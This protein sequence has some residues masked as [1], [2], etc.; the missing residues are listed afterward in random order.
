MSG[1][2]AAQELAA[3]IA[4][5]GAVSIAGFMEIALTGPGGYYT[6]QD[7][8]GRGGDFVTAPEISQMFGELLGLW[9]VDTWTRLGR[10]DPFRLIELG[11][12][13]GTLMADALRAA[14]RAPDFLAALDLHLVEVN[15][16]LVEIQ[17]RTL[18]GA[19]PQWHARLDAVPAG[20]SI[21]LANEFFDAL[22]IHQ[23]EMTAAG[24]RE[25]AVTSS[26]GGF[27]FAL[28]APGPALA[29]LAPAH[30]QAKAGEI[31]EICPAGLEIAAKIAGRLRQSPGAALVVDYGPAASAPGAS[32]QAVKQHRFHDPLTD[33]GAADLTAHVD[34]AALARAAERLGARV[35]G[36]ATQRDFL[37]AL[38]IE[39][40]AR[41]LQAAD[42]AAAGE[43][44]AARDRLIGGG[45]MGILFKV[46]AL[47][48]P[49]IDQLAGL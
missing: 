32:L 45:E 25:R 28:T 42:P 11:P 14:K 23:F 15:A 31:V 5:T 26:D 37:S 1:T 47:A 48:S 2:R 6:R 39:A 3:R 10:P 34:F 22:P 40:R 17:R 24:W 27:A 46:L 19:A 36:P 9:C 4:A 21:I 7:P 12:G 35:F 29:L 18:A 41:Q 8:L 43:I 16:G 33:I 13:R 30:L 49:G 20:P 38:G 44:A